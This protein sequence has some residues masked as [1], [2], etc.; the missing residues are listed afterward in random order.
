MNLKTFALV[1]FATLALSSYSVLNSVGRIDNEAVLSGL[2]GGASLYEP[3]ILQN[4][5]VIQDIPE[6]TPASTAAPTDK[7]IIVTRGQKESI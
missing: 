4:T 1:S 5:A 7:K 3:L 2:K 6:A